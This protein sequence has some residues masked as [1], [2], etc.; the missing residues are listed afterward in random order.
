MDWGHLLYYSLP[1]RSRAAS[2]S[3]QALRSIFDA[4]AYQRKHWR[5]FEG[6]QGTFT[7]FRKSF[8]FHSLPSLPLLPLLRPLPQ[9]PRVSQ[10]LRLQIWIPRLK[11]NQNT[12]FKLH[13]PPHQ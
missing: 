6:L 1:L 11:T 3:K 5:E 7:G 10:L 2:S 13:R 4:L 9:R 8:S 12:S